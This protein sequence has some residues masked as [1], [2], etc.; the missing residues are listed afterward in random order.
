MERLYQGNALNN[1]NVERR[2]SSN[3]RNLIR[4]GLA[5]GAVVT[6]LALLAT[7]TD[8]PKRVQTKLHNIISIDQSIPSN[9]YEATLY[10]V[11][12]GDTISGLT[13]DDSEVERYLKTANGIKSDEDLKSKVGDVIEMAEMVPYGQG[14]TITQLIDELSQKNKLL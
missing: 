14:K 10:T 11:K 7:Q 9:N 5:A 12:S 1:Q 8:L 6:G 2:D 4:R 3:Y 13:K